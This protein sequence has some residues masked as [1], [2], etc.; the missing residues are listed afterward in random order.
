MGVGSQRVHRGAPRVV[1]IG[2][3]I[4]GCSLAEELTARGWTDVTVLDQGPLFA[5][6]GSS[7]HAPGLVFQT[8]P[9]KTLAEFASYTVDKLRDLT[10]DGR[11]CFRPVG[12][13][14]VATTPAR[15]A[16]LARRHGLATSWGIEARLVDPAECARLHPL[17]DPGAV[18]GGL[19]VPTDGLVHAVPAGEAQARRAID[20]GARFLA[21][22]R[23]TGVASAA[24]RVSG[25]HTDQGF[26]PAD[27]VVCA[28]GFWGPD[29]GALAGLTVP[30]QPLA[31]QYATT[32]PVPALAGAVAEIS[33]PILRHQDADL[34]YREHGDRI[35]IGSYGHRPMP[36]TAAETERHENSCLPFTPDDFS[37]AWKQSLA[38]LPGLAETEVEVGINGVFS[39]TPDGMPLLGEHRDLPGFWVAEAVWVTHSAGVAKALAEW[40]VEGQPRTDVHECDLHRFTAVQ[41]SPEYVAERGAQQFVEV[42]DVVHPLAPPQVLRPLQVSPFHPRHTE[43]GAVSGEAGGWERPLWF[44]ANAALAAGIDLPERDAWSSQWWSPTAAAEAA[45]TRERVAMY[46]M[47][48]LTRIEVT[49]PGA[50]AFLQRLTSNDVDRPVGRVVYT[51]LLAADGGIRSDLTVARLGEQRFQVGANGP[52]DLDWFRQHAPEDGSVQ[53]RDTTTGTCGIGLWGPRARDVLQPL[54]RTDVSN[55]AFR[56]FTARELFVGGVPVTAL[57]VSYVGELGWELYTDAATGLRLWDVLWAAGQEHGVLAAGRSAFTSLRLEKG[58]RAWG[59]DMTTEHDPVEAGL[60]FAVRPGKAD[61]IGREALDRRPHP[62]RLAC[63]TLDDPATTVLGKEPVRVDGVPVGYVT[64]AAFGY[65]IGRSIAYA[66]LPA[67]HAEPGTA[68][69]IDWFGR[70][71]AA[72]VSVEPLVDP[73]G[74]TVRC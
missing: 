26:V 42:Y 60:E 66:W 23:V 43:L 62:R 71:V 35:G 51:L 21:R 31:H 65:T 58:Y 25:V 49:G 70:P 47:T 44:E 67:E 16:E 6:G 33:A 73:A 40:L 18:L 59:V 45:A 11:P 64:S 22:H 57:R 13:L 34:Y 28:A 8:N 46:D 12:G 24:G 20:R 56:Y 27:V 2:A 55:A 63:L 10:V 1:V 3:G 14:E 50:C 54:T 9:S 5:A 48:P 36:V 41:L 30:L 61:F 32:A 29:V 7:S 15:L 69:T 17:L 68:V 52:L 4:V 37:D 53:L 19:H 72:T 74:A 39:F 38:L